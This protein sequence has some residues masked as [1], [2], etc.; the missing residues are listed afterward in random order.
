MN[1]TAEKISMAIEKKEQTDDVY[2]FGDLGLIATIEI[3]SNKNMR[4]YSRCVYKNSVKI[5][6]VCYGFE[7]DFSLP[8]FTENEIINVVKAVEGNSPGYK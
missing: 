8:R 7:S 5:G 4:V 3:V 1:K 6:V 2:A